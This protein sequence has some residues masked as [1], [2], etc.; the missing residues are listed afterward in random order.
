MVLRKVNRYKWLLIYLYF[1]C[2]LLSIFF[3]KKNS[4][5]QEKIND[6]TPVRARITKFSLGKP[7]NI[8]PKQY[9]HDITINDLN[10]VL[11]K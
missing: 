3:N 6:I 4:R 5:L 10:N 1:F 7:N 9:N 8:Y 2:I 11:I